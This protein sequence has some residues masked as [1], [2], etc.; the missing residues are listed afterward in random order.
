MGDV[1]HPDPL[2][3]SRHRALLRQH[4]GQHTPVRGAPVND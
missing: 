2:E 3:R 4:Y 1:D